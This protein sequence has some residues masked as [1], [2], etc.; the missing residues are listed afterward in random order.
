LLNKLL[1]LFILGQLGANSYEN[2]HEA[3]FTLLIVRYL[4]LVCSLL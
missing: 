3:K 1:S 4:L 2:K